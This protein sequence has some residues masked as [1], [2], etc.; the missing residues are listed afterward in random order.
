MPELED[1]LGQVSVAKDEVLGLAQELVRIPSVNTG[2]MPTGD[3]TAV[4]EFARDWLRR[5][6]IT[7]EILE[8]VP[9]RGS[10]VSRLDGRS[11][12]RA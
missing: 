7:G 6:G 3:E 8:A 4:A 12:R 11:G 10:L 2:F 1:L 9:G 5:E